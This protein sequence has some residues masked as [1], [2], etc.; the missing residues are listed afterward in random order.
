[1]TAAY[2]GIS[3]IILAFIGG[4]LGARRG[5]A[6]NGPVFR[7]AAAAAVVSLLLAASAG[8]VANLALPFIAFLCSGIRGRMGKS[9]SG[10]TCLILLAVIFIDLGPTT[11]QSPFRKDLAF[12]REGMRRASERI[13]PHRALCGYGSDAGMHFFQWADGRQ[14]DLILP[15]GFFPQG[16]PLSLNSITATV[17][18]LNSSEGAISDGIRDLLYLWDVAALITWTRDGFTE[19]AVA[20][21]PVDGDDPPLAWTMPASPL[22]Y[23]EAAGIAL[24]DTLEGPYR[25]ALLAEYPEAGSPMRT[26]YMARMSQ[27]VGSMN[28]D[29]A[30]AT[31]DILFIDGKGGGPEDAPAWSEGMEGKTLAEFRS[32]PSKEDPS[33]AGMRRAGESPDGDRPEPFTV[34]DYEVNMYSA[35]IDFRSAGPGWVR[36]AFSWYP[37]LKVVLDGR[38][39]GFARSLLGAMII[40]IPAGEHRIEIVPANPLRIPPVLLMIAGVALMIIPM[41]IKDSAS[42]GQ[43]PCNEGDAP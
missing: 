2:I 25:R 20:G 4:C 29:R 33:A 21:A 6:R 13:T 38:P 1:M 8:R 23:S 39:V 10:R 35:G 26:K 24:D 31:A 42:A 36:I 5:G 7:A 43:G 40:R 41:R 30:G 22:I 32:P 27:W 28:I 15:T 14:T 18:A 16:A 9:L 11:V 3:V 12:I 19:P 17:D 34:D 37:S